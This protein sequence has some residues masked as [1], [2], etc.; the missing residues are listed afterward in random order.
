MISKLWAGCGISVP[1]QLLWALEL[2]RLGSLG[3]GYHRSVFFQTQN[4]MRRLFM[5]WMV[6]KPFQFTFAEYCVY[7][8]IYIFVYL[9]YI[10]NM[11]RCIY[12]FNPTTWFGS[13]PSFLE[14]PF[15][16]CLRWKFSNRWCCPDMKNAKG[17]TSCRINHVLPGWR[18]LTH[19][20]LW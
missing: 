20:D 4:W 17:H 12:N 16:I 3:H 18:K 10:H 19:F 9:F 1:S 14:I 11:L 5:K 6:L 13:L 15:T 8:Y 2:C 7:V